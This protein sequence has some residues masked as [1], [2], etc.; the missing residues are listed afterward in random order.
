MENYCRKCSGIVEER[1]V[2]EN[3]RSGRA[4]F[5]KIFIVPFGAVPVLNLR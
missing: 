5:G 1:L 4:E 2:M 3:S